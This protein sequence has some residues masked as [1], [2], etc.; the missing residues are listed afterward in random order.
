MSFSPSKDYLL[1]FIFRQQTSSAREY[2]IFAP[3]RGIV[4]RNFPLFYNDLQRT[5]MSLIFWDPTL[6][7]FKILK[8]RGDRMSYA[9]EIIYYDPGRDQKIVTITHTDGNKLLVENEKE[10][11][12]IY[13]YK[14]WS[15]I[16]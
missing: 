9:L 12:R 6:Q 2:D 5:Y 14:D 16:T 3:E 11:M 1:W 7:W 13:M 15:Y 10:K 4:Y 8:S